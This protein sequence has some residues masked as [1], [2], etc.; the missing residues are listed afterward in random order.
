MSRMDILNGWSRAWAGFM[1]THLWETILAFLVIMA[2]WGLLNKRVSPPLGYWLFMLILLKCLI[3]FQITYPVLTPYLLPQRAA[4]SVG[5][6]TEITWPAA[7]EFNKDRQR[8]PSLGQEVFIESGANSNVSKTAD[9]K[10]E[11]EY[12]AGARDRVTPPS[13]PTVLMVV[14]AMTVTGLLLRLGW[15]QWKLYR[16]IRQAQPVDW[17][18]SPVQFEPLKNLLGMRRPVRVVFSRSVD[19]PVVCGVIRPCLIVP[20][21][22][23]ACFSPNQIRWVLLHELAHV[24]RWDTFVAMIQKILQSIYLFNPIIWLTNWMIDQQREYACDDIALATCGA[25]RVDCGQGF[26]SLALRRSHK[27]IYATSVLGLF[28]YN[29]FVRRRMMRI[30][31]TQRK[32]HNG[33]SIG[34]MVFLLVVA[35]LVLPSVR[36]ADDRNDQKN[37]SVMDQTRISS[38][39]TVQ[40]ATNKPASIL[41][42]RLLAEG[43][44]SVTSSLPSTNGKFVDGDGMGNLIVRELD[45]GKTRRIPN[46]EEKVDSYIWFSSLSPD[47]TRVVYGCWDQDE[48]KGAVKVIG[49]DGSSRRVL[50]AHEKLND[51]Y[52]VKWSTDGKKILAIAQIDN[53][54]QILLIPE[55]GDSHQVVKILGKRRSD[56]ACFSP[57]GSFIA[58]DVSNQENS[59]NYDI[60]LVSVDGSHEIPL[61]QTPANDKLL[62]WSPDGRWIFYAT[63]LSG[64]MDTYILSV[65]EGKP[66][67]FPRLIKKYIGD[68]TPKGFTRDGSF[69]YSVESSNSGIYTA[70]FDFGSGKF[71]SPPT[72]IFMGLSERSISWSPDGNTLSYFKIQSENKKILCLWSADSGNS[73]EVILP[74]GDFVTS[75]WSSDGKSILTLNRGKGLCKIDVQTGKVDGIVTGASGS[76]VDHG[77]WLPDGRT[78]LTCHHEISADKKD[79]SKSWFGIRN[80]ETG[81]ERELL[82][83]K[84]ITWRYVLSP[85]GKWLA[86]NVIDPNIDEYGVLKVVPISGGEPREVLDKLPRKDTTGMLAWTPDSKALLYMDGNSLRRISVLGKNSSPQKLCVFELQ[87]DILSI[88]PDGQR[89]A[90]ICGV[91]KKEIWVMENFLPSTPALLRDYPGEEKT[92]FIAAEKIKSPTSSLQITDLL[93]TD[94]FDDGDIE[95][96][97]VFEDQTIGPP[98]E[99]SIK[100]GELVLENTRVSIGRP[101]WKNYR[102]KVRFSPRTVVDHRSGGSLMFRRKS[103]ET[104]Y[105][106]YIFSCFP[107]NGVVQLV[108]FHRDP[109]GNKNIAA[110]A[111]TRNI[112]FD[113]D[114]WYTLQA[115][116][117]G[118]NIKGYVDGKLVFDET[119]DE[120]TEG[121][122]ALKAQDRCHFDDF[123]IQLLP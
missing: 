80:L 28:N 72:P 98:F 85:D 114:K 54:Y 3:P 41:T 46:A 2:I 81:E 25:P 97:I 101:D 19:I 112:R 21:D 44:L 53:E 84:H 6:W 79:M 92:A 103:D 40:A 67:G 7:I 57:N 121:N 49:L 61:V 70:K 58:Y 106:F 20:P 113:T 76:Y 116:V 12:N 39:G 22:F 38:S 34:A 14:W 36:A 66:Q 4:Q 45:S 55:E 104:T 91:S 35:L 23:F 59:S 105:D 78:I 48:N 96:W 37:T 27:P 10:N 86:Y 117:I 15:M 33:L 43:K 16:L 93:I 64:S 109:A 62:G 73:R 11:T 118:N 18:S 111:T 83:D 17:D 87:P 68:I 94:N 31:D 65:S 5:A 63:N 100:N 56:N 30:L 42:L 115:D 99:H 51:F 120:I 82:S 110:L 26:L 9:P 71:L 32:L 77:L 90:I 107:L 47:S 122:I 102:I 29:T 24:R 13:I 123:S 1:G 75:S 89:I 50:F 8:G 119:N 52:S 95:G 88:H 69:Y 74:P 108:S 60:Y